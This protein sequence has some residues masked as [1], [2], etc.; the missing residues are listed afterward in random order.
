[1]LVFGNTGADGCSCFCVAGDYG[2]VTAVVATAA[3]ANAVRFAFTVQ[4][5]EG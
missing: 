4:I 1:M 2:G 3:A 5:I